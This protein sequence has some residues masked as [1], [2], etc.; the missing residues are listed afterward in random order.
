M[1]CV[2]FA[3]IQS[4]RDNDR[5]SGEWDARGPPH[6]HPPRTDSDLRLPILVQT[7]G[8]GIKN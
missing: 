7:E 5:S 6:P 8:F 1:I 4:G 2:A 3:E